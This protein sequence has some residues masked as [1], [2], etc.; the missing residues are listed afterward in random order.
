MFCHNCGKPVDDNVSVCPE[1]GAH[2]TVP[3]NKSAIKLEPMIAVSA[4][5]SCI[6]FIF[7]FT[8]VTTTFVTG[9]GVSDV[10]LTAMVPAFVSL[11][12]CVYKLA[13]G[14]KDKAN[15]ITAWISV[16][17]DIVLLIY[18]FIGIMVFLTR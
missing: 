1:C 11:G 5:I 9:W 4:L 10:E 6:A 13:A 3:Q 7:G 8:I 16:T 18:A 15:R 17:V 12:L 2:L 14:I